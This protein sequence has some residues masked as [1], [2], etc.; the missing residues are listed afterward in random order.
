M[1]RYRNI[2]LWGSLFLASKYMNELFKEEA[3]KGIK[4]N[5]FDYFILLILSIFEGLTF[6]ELNKALPLDVKTLHNKIISLIKRGLIEREFSDN[7]TSVIEITK[8]GKTVVK[9]IRTNFMTFFEDYYGIDK[10]IELT[11][12][13]QRFNGEMRKG[14]DLTIPEKILSK[15]KISS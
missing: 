8:E 14:L 15:M 7:G 6:Y 3:P 4:L 13:L 1:E 5:S 9:N 10:V 11:E 12:E 2:S